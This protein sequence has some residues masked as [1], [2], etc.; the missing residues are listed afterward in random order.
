MAKCVHIRETALEF[1]KVLISTD[2]EE[3]IEAA[4]TEG[5]TTAHATAVASFEFSEAF[6]AEFDRRYNGE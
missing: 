1:A 2:Q 5:V 3:L 4:Q 6:H